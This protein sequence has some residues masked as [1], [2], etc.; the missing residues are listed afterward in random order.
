MK[1]SLK[2]V[3]SLVDHSGLKPYLREDEIARLIGEASE[4]GNYSVCIEPI[5]GNFAVEYIKEKGYSL[6]VD[7][8]LDF[9]FGSLPTS[10]RKKIIEDSVY[11]DE[12]DMVIPIGY[13]KSHRWDKVE[14]DINDVV[15]T[16]RDLGLVSKIITEDGYLT[17][18]EKLKTYDIV[19]RSAPDFIKTSTGF[20]DKEFCKSLGNETGATPENV[21]LMSEIA[22]KIGSNIGIKAAGGIHTYD[23]VE[24]IIDSAG[25]IPEPS[26]I[27]LGMSGTKKLYEE[28][29]KASVQ[30]S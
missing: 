26:N 1:Y 25:M 8:T 3:M 15:S 14:Q 10:A 7:V 21:K 13:V 2:T 16:A 12:I 6:K 27:R 17:L 22:K 5:Y 30:Q 20:A 19:I 23:Q 11:A 28:M 29:K 4:M 18:D 24:K 9:P